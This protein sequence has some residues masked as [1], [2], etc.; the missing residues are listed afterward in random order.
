LDRWMRGDAER[1]VFLGQSHLHLAETGV[2]GSRERADAWFAHAAAR[3]PVV[4]GRPAPPGTDG[5][6]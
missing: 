5:G 4:F 1:A 2:A 3:S 6:R